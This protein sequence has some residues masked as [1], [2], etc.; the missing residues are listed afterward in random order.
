VDAP[1]LTSSP[2]SVSELSNIVPLGNL[3]PVATR[4]RATTFYLV[5]A[6]PANASNPPIVKVLSPGESSR[7][8]I[9]SSNDTQL[10]RRNGLLDLLL[11]LLRR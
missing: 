4:F 1:F 7:T 11:R 9:A 8:G 3:N 6:R 10:A 2:V 5:L